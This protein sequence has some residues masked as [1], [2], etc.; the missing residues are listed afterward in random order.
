M[1]LI[2]LNGMKA[3]ATQDIAAVPNKTYLR[4]GTDSS[5]NENEKD[6]TAENMNAS[7]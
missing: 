1:P 3:M 6:G 5:S 4:S 2:P 7:K